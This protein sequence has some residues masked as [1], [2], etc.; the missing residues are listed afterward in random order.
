MG[1][2]RRAV[3]A[4]LVAW[5]A[6]V[7]W[8]VVAVAQKP[9]SEPVPG[10]GVESDSGALRVVCEEAPAVFD[11]L[12]GSYKVLQERYLYDVIDEDLAA[13]AARGVREAGLH[14]RGEEDGDA[15][16]CAL[17]APAFEQTCAEIDAV[18]DTEA[19][20]WAASE[21]MF[22]SRGDQ[23]TFLMSPSEYEGL[24]SRLASGRSYSGI[25]LSLGLL[26]GTVPCRELSAVCRPAVAEVFSGS[27][28][29]RAGLMADDILLAFDDYVPSGSGCGLGGLPSFEP[30]TSVTVRVERDGREMSFVVEVDRSRL[31]VV[32]GR[33]VADTTGYL[34]LGS[35]IA[36]ADSAV[37]SELQK[38][39]EA[40]A[41][42]LVV[43]LRG[44]RGGLLKTA[45]SIVG[46]FLDGGQVVLQEVSGL[47]TVRHLVEGHGAL[48]NPVVL[49]V[50]VAVDG[51]SASASEVMT[52]ALRDHG[53]A[54]VVGGNTFGKDTGQIN[55]A[56]YGRD[57]TLL[58]GARVTVFRWLGPD[59]TSAAGGIEP[60]V[61]IDFSGC[62]HPVGLAR[63]VAAA[64]G[65]G[66]AVA[67]DIDLGTERF[68]AV[69]A[70]TAD[71]VLAGSECGPGL[72]CPGEPVPRWMMAVWL[73]RVVD[74]Q[75]PEPVSASRFVDVDADRWWAAYVERLA[76][77]GI[78][79]GC[80]SEPARY[81]PDDPVT[82]A[83]MATF[84]GKAFVLDAA[85]PQG[86]TDTGDSVHAANIDALYRAGITKG[87]SAEPL[88]FCPQQATT[89]AQ[90]ALFLQQA[91]TR[92]T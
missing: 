47:E 19:A 25:G 3:A 41:E 16:P 82:R 58:G 78:T 60:D 12:C 34:R 1:L 84:L 2:T 80:A 39:L 62:W 69:A 30:G 87:C 27:P 17:P 85:V 43:D 44:N 24:Q 51:S 77:L 52:L 73:V 81:C 88:R 35:F 14:P 90:M 66:G 57:G 53:R 70:L 67:A 86:F 61:E 48:A 22:E 65:L 55:E 49:P 40:G 74:G 46:M 50:A 10:V 42:N 38:L 91:R 15:P 45:I 7:A 72:L 23:H 63:Q 21:R 68:D 8:P 29:E 59:G 18:S 28:A 4:A 75:D 76:E 89:R 6:L 37:A 33:I 9:E 36:S 71:G 56:L 20:V 26:E 11:L 64:A 83:Q 32:G 31:P 92:L 13:A 5:S 79:G 54:V